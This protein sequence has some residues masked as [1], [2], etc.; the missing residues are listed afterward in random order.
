MRIFTQEDQ[1]QMNQAAIELQ[2]EGLVSEDNEQGRHNGAVLKQYFEQNPNTQMTVQSVKAAANSLRARLHWIH[3]SA[4]KIAAD[5]AAYNMRQEDIDLIFAWMPQYSLVVDGDPGLINFTIIANWFA[6][7]GRP[8]T[9][10]DC[11][12]A[13]KYLQGGQQATRLTFK[14][15]KQPYEIENE[16]RRLEQS[17]SAMIKGKSKV[18]ILDPDIPQLA[19]HLRHHK[20]MMHRPTEQITA[21][22]PNLT[23]EANEWKSKAEMV[24][25]RSH[26]ENERI[27]QIVVYYRGTREVDWQATHKARDLARQHYDIRMSMVR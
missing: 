21:E 15:Q 16:R 8:V 17:A 27:Q 14:T 2:I 26:V 6:Q 5:Y 1:Q 22:N 3:K 11:V 20:E 13:M 18:E 10:P 25:T 23:R 24:R 4:A 9:A 7:D 19:P 12:T